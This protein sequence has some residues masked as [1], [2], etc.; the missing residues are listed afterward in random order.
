VEFDWVPLCWGQRASK[1]RWTA[2]SLSPDLGFRL[3]GLGFRLWG[4]GFTIEW[5]LMA[6]Q[7]DH[8]YHHTDTQTHTVIDITTQTHTVCLSVCLAFCLSVSLCLSLPQT[9]TYT[10]HVCH[11]THGA[12][13]RD[14]SEMAGED[15]EDEE[16]SVPLD[17]GDTH[18]RRQ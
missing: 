1:R 15:R 12:H 4:L 11:R 2:P 7:D 9:K 13:G 14:R 3:W 5:K 18:R 17:G 6:V 10:H 8:R 16:A